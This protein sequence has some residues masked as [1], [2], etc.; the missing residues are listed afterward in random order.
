MLPFNMVPGGGA[1]VDIGDNIANSLMLDS[2]A[3]QY[4]SLTLGA[5]PTNNNIGTLSCWAKKVDTS[6][7]LV[8]VA[9]LGSGTPGS[10]TGFVG[11][12]GTGALGAVR[13][14][15]IALI[16]GGATKDYF[17]SQ[18]RDPTGW[19]HYCIRFDTTQAV[20]ADRM[21]VEIDGALQTNL[22]AALAL[23]EVLQFNAASAPTQIGC[24]GGTAGYFS[25]CY[26]AM[27][28]W[29]DGQALPAT[30]FGRVSADT[31]QW[32][33]KNYTGTYG[34]F[35]RRY[36]FS[37]SGA[38]GTDSSGNGNHL[39]LNGGITSANQYTDTPTNNSNV[40]NALIPSASL[41]IG[42]TK[43]AA[44]TVARG[45]LGISSGLKA[46]WEI[47]STGG[48]TTAGM[49][50]NTG[51]V[52]ATTTILAGVTKGFRFDSGAGTFDWTTDGT[53]W[54][55]IATGLATTPYFTYC[56]T[57][58]GTTAVINS[59]AK[60]WT[61]GGTT[62][63]TG[64]KALCTANLPT[65]AIIKPSLHFQTLLDTGANIKT[66]LAALFPVYLNWI[67]DRANANNHQLIDTVRGSSAVL[68]SNTTAAETTYTAPAG[69]SVGW[70][71]NMG[72]AA[73]T[74]N[75]G[76]ISSQV[77]ANVLAGQSVVTYTGTGVNATVGHGLGKA[78]ELVIA[79]PRGIIGSYSIYSYPAAVLR[80]SDQALS[81]TTDAS[82]AA[83]T[84]FQS[85]QP[86]ATVVSVG[87]STS[88]NGNGTTYLAYCFYSVEGYSK[89]GSFPGNGS[90]DGTFVY[91]GFKSRYIWIKRID[92]AADWWVLDTVRDT[93]NPLST[94][95]YP[96]LASADNVGSSLVIDTTVTGFKARSTNA[97]VNT[98]GG[99]YIFYAV[100]EAPTKYSTAR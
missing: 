5:T 18:L 95:L 20:A 9:M 23:N 15:R 48:T 29:I 75:A 3:S 84:L 43:V 83:P 54:N 57:A 87:T 25:N 79:K 38:L 72:G 91:C 69:S 32:V 37:N 2:G 78:L 7:N 50:D 81:F 47:T 1:S 19:R 14:N 21:K 77:S 65:P 67:K 51:T 93:Y 36:D 40:W 26:L 52:T 92:A 98:A 10:N 100:A 4:G 30:N 76:S 66:N 28:H 99:T 61:V 49:L 6:V 11:I 90:A 35:G 31:G 64:F 53:S 56:S 42:N 39:T 63:P 46:Y 13:D 73:V 45:T 88:I 22:G 68:Q 62:P 58:G 8:D 74:N 55:S 94:L 16:N 41:T 71:W 86:T 34:N 60:T 82:F 24:I 97:N 27:W 89:I 70:A 96:N 85:T 12:A 59:G 33:P 80:G 44:S 17:S